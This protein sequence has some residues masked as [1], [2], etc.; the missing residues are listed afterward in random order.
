M[1]KTIILTSVIALMLASFSIVNACGNKGKSSQASTTNS[2]NESS[3][4]ASKMEKAA[5]DVA[6]SKIQAQTIEMKQ[7]SDDKSAQAITCPSS[8]E[9]CNGKSASACPYMKNG[10]KAQDTKATQSKSKNSDKTK[11]DKSKIALNPSQDNKLTLVNQE[12][13]Q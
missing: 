10:M 13:A 9:G 4:C 7:N 8:A 3:S 12:V 6:G 5:V 11:A 1:R 2:T